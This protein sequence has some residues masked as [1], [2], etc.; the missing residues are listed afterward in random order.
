MESIKTDQI[1]KAKEL[2]QLQAETLTLRT[3]ADYVKDYISA[4][5]EKDTDFSAK[6]ND[7][8][9]N[10]MDCIKYIKDHALKWLQ[11][12]QKM[13]LGDYCNGVGGDVPN[14]VC[15]N[16]ALDY[17]NSKPEPKEGSKPRTSLTKTKNDKANKTP[18]PIAKHENE[19]IKPTVPVVELEK[20]INPPIPAE[21]KI[22]NPV[23]MSLLEM[24]L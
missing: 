20:K 2:L 19:A 6:V 1:T 10:F 17:Y 15:Y 23:Q 4:Y 18:V 12:Q 22:D 3:M 21:T 7:P 11:E 5:C 24:G 14:D 9:K 13:E 16:W 8:A